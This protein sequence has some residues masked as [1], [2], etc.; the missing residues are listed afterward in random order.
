MPTAPA[1]LQ[2]SSILVRAPS[3]A[4]RVLL[5]PTG[6]QSP[7]K[8]AALTVKAAQRFVCDARQLTARMH[9]APT[10]PLS[11]FCVRVPLKLL[12]AINGKCPVDDLFQQGTWT[13]GVIPRCA[14]EPRRP[15]AYHRADLVTPRVTSLEEN[16]VCPLPS[17]RRRKSETQADISQ[18]RNRTA[19]SGR[20]CRCQ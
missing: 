1:V 19:W 6:L 2:R 15:R 5:Q 13:S 3:Q 18:S 20:C 11:V 7:T 12:S 9:M 10:Y 4:A 8:T 14:C 17:G 16:F